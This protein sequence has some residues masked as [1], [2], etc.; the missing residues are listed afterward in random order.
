VLNKKIRVL[1]GGST[2]SKGYF[3]AK[4]IEETLEPNCFDHVFLLI[5]KELEK[6]NHS[7]IAKL[8]DN[9]DAYK[10]A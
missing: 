8:Y 3:I 5:C 10:M 6:S 1:I 7:T 4:V 9:I 2:G